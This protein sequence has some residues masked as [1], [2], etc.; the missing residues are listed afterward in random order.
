MRKMWKW[1]QRGLLSL[2]LVAVLT[3][4]GF[5]HASSSSGKSPVASCAMGSMPGM[6]CC[7]SGK[8][9]NPLCQQMGQST[10]SVSAVHGSA[11]AA[12]PVVSRIDFVK[13]PMRAAFVSPV[14]SS[15]FSPPRVFLS[16]RI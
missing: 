2:G 12:V 1:L 11:I 3:P 14:G 6:A 9:P 13:L 5:C 16:L 4:C 15:D 8:S 10:V 7:H